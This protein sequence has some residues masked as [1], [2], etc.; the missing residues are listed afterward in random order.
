MRP[1]PDA[2]MAN[3][4][5]LAAGARDAA[6]AHGLS[7]PDQFQVVGCGNDPQVCFVGTPPEQCRYLRGEALGIRAAR[8]ALKVMLEPET[9]AARGVRV[10]PLL[11]ARS[12]T[13]TVPSKRRQ[14]ERG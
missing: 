13:R 1:A 9:V 4:D 8:L 2:V 12:T 11:V 14:K 10:T 3:G 6:A 5:V 7:I